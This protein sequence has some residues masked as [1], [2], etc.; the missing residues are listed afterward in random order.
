MILPSMLALLAL[1]VTDPSGDAFGDGSLLPPTAP[2]Y[3]SA[4]VFDLQTVSLTAV[5]SGT[6]IA[7]TLGALGVI[8][9]PQADEPATADA[10]A[11]TDVEGSL[12]DTAEEDPERPLVGYLP[13]I[14]DVYL[15]EVPGGHD[16]TLPGP[17]LLFPQGVG[18]QY[19]LRLSSGGAFYVEYPLPV[20][21]NGRPA[22]EPAPEPPAVSELVREPL[23]LYRTSDTLVAYLPFALSEDVAVQALVGVY[24]PF[25]QT[26]WRPLSPTPSAWAFSGSGDQSSPVVDLIAPDAAT[27]RAALQSGVLPKTATPQAVRVVPWL[28]VMGG[29]LLIAL[30]GLFLRAR[31]PAAAKPATAEAEA[32]APADEAT[33]DVT[34]DP[35]P[36]PALAAEASGTDAEDGGGE[37]APALAA[38][39]APAPGDRAE[40]ATSEDEPR[41]AADDGEDPD[42]DPDE[43]LDAELIDPRASAADA[44]AADVAA[45]DAAGAEDQELLVDGDEE[46]VLDTGEREA[47]AAALG[48]NAGLP[49]EAAAA[50]ES[51][52]AVGVEPE[53]GERAAKFAAAFDEYLLALDDPKT[54]DDFL[55]DYGDDENFWHPRSRKTPVP[56]DEPVAVDTPVETS[57]GTPVEASGEAGEANES[58]TT[59]GP[60]TE[61]AEGDEQPQPE[62]GAEPPQ[63]P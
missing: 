21:V 38:A 50:E 52:P 63:A 20:E 4:A 37:G 62:E 16:R 30:V 1:T 49:A 42:E 34:S 8:G 5:P 9:G 33:V 43:D 60:T 18:W 27:Q 56:T 44:L 6:R 19:A 14:I 13:A 26:G 12:T 45:A 31:V 54:L 61:R 2:V 23:D 48:A 40:G 36:P 25:S 35:A 32:E 58:G 46:V 53:L 7:L 11:P 15:G 41:A 57:I 22:E 47:A 17:D 51:A 10:G 3:A 29:G 55:G 28:W 39:G 24:D 59:T